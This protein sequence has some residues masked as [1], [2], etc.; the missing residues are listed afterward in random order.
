MVD[1]NYIIKHLDITKT[2]VVFILSSGLIQIS[3]IKINPYSKLVKW[4]GDVACSSTH[5]DINKLFEKLDTLEQKQTETENK[6]NTSIAI[7]Q[8]SLTQLD[9]D[10][11]RREMEQI[12]RHILSFYEGMKQNNNISMES[13]KSILAD[14]DDYNDYCK[15]HEDFRNGYTTNAV[16]IIRQSALIKM[17]GIER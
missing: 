3:P 2:F 5:E 9:K 15:R 12:R 10:S 16:D 13:Y 6:L 1:I 8:Q 17:K 7:L 11:S 4:V 14:I